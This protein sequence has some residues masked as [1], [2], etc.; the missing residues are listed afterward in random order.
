MGQ[1][2]LV[3]VSTPDLDSA[4]RI[5]SVMNSRGLDLSPSDIFK[6]EVIGEFESEEST[7]YADKWENAEE[8][9]G[10]DVFVDLFLH[11]RL[12]HSLKRSEQ[13]LLK[14]FPTQ[15]LAQYLPGRAKEFVDDVLEPY[16]SAYVQ[17]NSFS[18]AAAE[19]AEKVNAWFKRLAQLDTND[20]QAP[21]LWALRHHGD[22]PEWLNA[23]FQRLD[24]L[25]S[26][27]FIRREYVTPRL[28]RYL[29]L[30]RQLS[31]GH[32]LNASAFELDNEEQQNTLDRLN[33]DVY[34]TSKTRKFVLLRLDE[35]LAKNPGVTYERRI[36]TVEHVLPQ[37]PKRESVWSKTFTDEQ[38]AEWTHRIANL[39][40]LNQ[41]KNSE[42]QN[43]DFAEKKS[44][45]FWGSKGAATFAL[46][47]QV[48]NHEEWTPSVL[49]SRQTELVAELAA[50]WSLA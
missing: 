5:F 36:V 32:G 30:L 23:F 43:F 40:L 20:W 24:R 6:A 26:S 42:A 22:D 13:S 49:E 46:T 38:R 15:V 35:I 25:A 34:S 1:T 50:A 21:A 39:V 18:Y 27:M 41:V 12:I 47:S 8:A 33:G 9:V 10:R 31:E 2:F 28:L 14:E 19:G 37:N 16:A 7:K 17:L 11:I 45:Y 3:A 48:L 44:K 4:H 29:D